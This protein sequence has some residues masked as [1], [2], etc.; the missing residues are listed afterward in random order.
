[1]EHCKK[2]FLKYVI[3]YSLRSFA[4]RWGWRR[5][6]TTGPG[7]GSGACSGKSGKAR[8][9]RPIRDERSNKESTKLGT[10]FG[11]SELHVKVVRKI[12]PNTALQKLWPPPPTYVS[13]FRQERIRQRLR[14][15][16]FAKKENR[17]KCLIGPTIRFRINT[18]G[19]VF[20]KQE[21]APTSSDP[22][23]LKI[24]RLIFFGEID[25][26]ILPRV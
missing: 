13:C 7:R 16:F 20:L 2:N 15:K 18:Q 8:S 23:P 10:Y 9:W 21:Q 14:K 5:G 24:L 6:P 25:K 17:T 12:E 11:R 22:D 4:A 1:M 26:C 19:K 3:V